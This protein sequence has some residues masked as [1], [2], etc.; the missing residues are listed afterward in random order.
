MNE[1]EIVYAPAENQSGA[2]P[3]ISVEQAKKNAEEGRRPSSGS[4]S[5]TPLTSCTPPAPPPTTR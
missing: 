3:A 2:A 5:G 1:H 4:F